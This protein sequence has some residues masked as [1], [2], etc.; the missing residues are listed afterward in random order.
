MRTIPSRFI[1]YLELRKQA[2]VSPELYIVMRN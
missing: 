2:S 1:H